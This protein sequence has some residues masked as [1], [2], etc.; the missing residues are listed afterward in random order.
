MIWFA[1]LLFAMVF[2]TR[3]VPPRWIALAMLAAAGIALIILF[4]MTF[5]IQIVPR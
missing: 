4:F 3:L 2:I 1:V 5:T